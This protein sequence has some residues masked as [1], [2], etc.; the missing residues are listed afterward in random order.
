MV[1][2]SN[3]MT[4]L[5]SGMDVNGQGQRDESTSG[6]LPG[7]HMQPEYFD[8][9][10]NNTINQC[11]TGISLGGG[12]ETGSTS[13]PAVAAVY[14]FGQ[15]YRDNTVS[16]SYVSGVLNFTTSQPS[17]TIPTDD[18]LLLDGNSFTAC[19]AGIFFTDQGGSSFNPTQQGSTIATGNT[20][21]MSGAVNP[22]TVPTFGNPYGYGIFWTNRVSLLTALDDNTYSNFSGGNYNNTTL[23]AILEEPLRSFKEYASKTL[24][25]SVT[26]SLELW[27]DGTSSL[28]WT[29]TVAYDDSSSGWLSTSPSSGTIASEDAVSSVNFTCNG[30][31]LTAGTYLG[32]ITATCGSQ[33]RTAQVVFVVEP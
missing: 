15:I 3:T 32:H 6:L 13:F 7:N 26:D 31:S 1:I 12:G 20:F 19:P 25:G 18:M 23:G 14:N 5:D 28:S 24:A 4:C 30:S 10:T 9:V 33:T 27:N 8:L 17:G 29:V 16:N 22:G 2:D 21:N 11:F